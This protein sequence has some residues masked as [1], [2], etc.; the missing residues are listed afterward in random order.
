MRTLFVRSGQTWI[1]SLA[2]FLLTTAIVALAETPEVHDYE[3]IELD[4]TR[5]D[6]SVDLGVVEDRGSKMEGPAVHQRRDVRFVK[7]LLEIKTKSELCKVLEGRVI[8]YYDI[9]SLVEG[10]RQRL[11]A[12]ADVL[13]ELQQRRHVETLE[14]PA[15]V[16][17]RIPFGRPLDRVDVVF[18]GAVSGLECK[19]FEGAYVTDQGQNFYLIEGCTKRAFA[20]SYQLR[21]HNRLGVPL[22]PL[23]SET[24]ARIPDGKAIAT[25]TNDEADILFRMDGDVVWSRLFREKGSAKSPTDS[26]ERIEKILE[27]RKKPHLSMQVCKRVEGRVI[28]FYS[29]LF[30]VE[31]CARRPIDKIPLEAQMWLDGQGGIRDVSPEEFV[32][33]KEGRAI[34]EK[35]LLKKL[36][37]PVLK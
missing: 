36:G 33:I 35:D 29:R 19:R 15:A 9:V 10:C 14:V 20:D 32:V 12:D 25:S 24:L 28:S 18:G 3:V 26:P 16:Y 17:R 34:S 11:I 31:A 7:K 23:S 2:G 13:A 6:P 5:V 1:L 27:N 21:L 8:S 4:A 37:L 22:M 30:L